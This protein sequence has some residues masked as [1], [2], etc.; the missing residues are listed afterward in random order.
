MH[1]IF[2]LIRKILRGA[3]Y[4]EPVVL[5]GNGYQ[6]RELVY[7]DDFVRIMLRLDAQ[8]ENDL[9]NIGAGEEF[10]IRHFAKLIADRVGYDVGKIT[11]DTTKYVGAESKC[12]ST[13]KLRRLIPDLQMTP[14]EDGLTRTIAWFRTAMEPTPGA[15]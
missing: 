5:W 13:A 9:I 6:K 10:T 15:R 7:V 4:N 14:L 12:L 3:L 1:F 8:C 2:D 11:F